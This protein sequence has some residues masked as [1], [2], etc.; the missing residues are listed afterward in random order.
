MAVLG[1]GTREVTSDVGEVT[2]YGCRRAIPGTQE[3]LAVMRNEVRMGLRASI[4]DAST[5]GEG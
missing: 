4:P 1:A 5:E 3:W 2:C